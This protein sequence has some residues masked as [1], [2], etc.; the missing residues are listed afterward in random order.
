MNKN[1]AVFSSILL[2]TILIFQSSLTLATEKQPGI[3]LADDR[4]K[5]LFSQN[6]EI[7]FSPASIF[8]I[9][10]SLAAVDAFGTDHRFK[11]LFAYD[12][13]SKNLYIKGF[14]DPLFISEVINDLTDQIRFKTNARVINHIILDSTFFNSDITIPGT[15]TSSNPYDATTGALCANFNTISFKWDTGLKKFI[16]PEPQTPL[17]P[18]FLGDVKKSGQ[19]QGRILLSPKQRQEYPGL[20]I[21]YFLTKRGISVNG[22]VKQ[23]RFDN[24]L[25]PTFAFESPFSL[26]QIL[27][28][29]LKYSNNF[30]ANQLMLVMGAKKQGAPATLEKGVLAMKTFGRE[31]LGLTRLAI[32]EGSGLSRENKISP[33]QMLK[34]LMQFMPL[35][36]L[37]TQEKNEYYKTGTLSD[38][39]CRAGF[40]RG[41]DNRLYP[42]VIMINEKDKGYA[43]IRQDL[44]KKVF[45]ISTKP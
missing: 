13:A 40:I 11:T 10:T 27:Q 30:M 26:E 38:V 22:S 14:G 29:L 17:L 20:L 35:H 6:K 15:G 4:G 44:L 3:L 32:A 7:L 41:N 37:L 24:A 28:K 34:V 19:K 25:S 21:K 33:D 43:K 2:C 1:I 39:R 16:S 8:K 42:F 9:F 5:I 23:G 45:R 18:D 36:S 31:K 12:R